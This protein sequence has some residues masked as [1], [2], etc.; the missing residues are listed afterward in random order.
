MGDC[1]HSLL[2]VPEFMHPSLLIEAGDLHSSR[3][4][5]RLLLKPLPLGHK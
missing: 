4:I 1:S 2:W 5:V 3:W